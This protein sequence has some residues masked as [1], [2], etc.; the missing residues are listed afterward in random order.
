[1]LEVKVVVG[2]MKICLEKGL[3]VFK[4]RPPQKLEKVHG[5]AIRAWGFE[6]AGY[7]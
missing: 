3:Q 4:E 5:Y 7:G 1:L 2:R 6:G